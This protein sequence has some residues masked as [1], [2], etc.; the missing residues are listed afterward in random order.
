VRT[1][2]RISKYPNPNPGTERFALFS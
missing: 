2:H 1:K